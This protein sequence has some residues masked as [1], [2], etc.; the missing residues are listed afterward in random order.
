MDKLE[1]HRLMHVMAVHFIFGLVIGLIFRP[2]AGVRFRRIAQPDLA[3]RRA[4]G[5]LILFLAGF[6]ETFGIVSATAI[7]ILPYEDESY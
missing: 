6:A 1:Y 4:T 5:D 7:M 3:S 2:V